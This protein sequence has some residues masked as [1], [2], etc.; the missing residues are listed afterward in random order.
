MK[1]RHPPS[2]RGSLQAP[3]GHPEL[4]W[5][6]AQLLPPPCPFGKG[7]EPSQGGAQ[8]DGYHPP[9]GAQVKCGGSLISLQIKKRKNRLFLQLPSLFPSCSPVHL[10]VLSDPEKSVFSASSNPLHFLWFL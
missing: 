6:P 9:R 5:Q 8:E 10:P 2:N 1:R 7:L 4:G 3:G